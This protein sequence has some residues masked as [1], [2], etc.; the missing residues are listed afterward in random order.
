MSYELHLLSL[1][2]VYG[3]SA[4]GLSLCVGH[5]GQLSMAQAASFGVGAY[6]Y[7]VFAVAYSLPSWAA[8]GAATGIAVVFALLQGFIARSL[9]EDELVFGTLAFNVIIAGLLINGTDDKSRLGSLRNLTNGPYGIT[10]VPPLPS[11]ALGAEPWLLTLSIAVVVSI[12]LVASYAA[13]TSPWGRLL[14]AI[15]DSPTLALSLGKRVF[16]ERARAAEA[17]SFLG[18]MAG[19]LYAAHARYVDPSVAATD[20]SVFF[21]TCLLLG[22]AASF[23]GPLL[24]SAGV[25]L[26]P[27]A[28]R[29]F[30]VGGATVASL[31]EIGYAAVLFA[32]LHLRPGGLLSRGEQPGGKETA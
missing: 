1:V 4:L 14:R 3:L 17:A 28:L 2:L 30:G 19:A 15:R 20:L 31:R 8:L 29:L 10:D 25:V 22:G 11:R 32:L 21:L 24:G 27:E 13:I 12:L 16:S 26:L 5:V 6:A 9:A 23:W 18:S 7:A